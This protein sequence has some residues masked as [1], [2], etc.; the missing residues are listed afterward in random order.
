MAKVL[1]VDDDKNI[2][3]VLKYNLLQEGFNVVTAED[4]IQALELARREKPDLILLDIM[5][6]GVDGLEVC[7]ILRKEMPVPILMLTAKIDEID[8]VVGLELG[9]DDYITKPFSIRE[10]MARIRATVR[11]SHWNEQQASPADPSTQT[12][13]KADNLEVDVSGH[14][15]FHEGKVINLSPKEFGL[16]AFLMRHRGQVFN[17]EQLVEQIW[18]YDFGGTART[19]DVHILSLRRKIGDN[20]ENPEHLLT[21]H[22]L[23]YKFEG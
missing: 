2:L 18:G 4:G 8:K 21:V 7:R 12:V 13:L 14:R 11:R 17:R 9:A 1:I 20:A 22:G 10:L 19:V 3:E 16:L 23:G 5:L 6:P 15:V